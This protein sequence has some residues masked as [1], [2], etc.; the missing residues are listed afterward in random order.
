MGV[1]YIVSF[2]VNIIDDN[3]KKA[4][5]A[6]CFKWV[7]LCFSNGA[8]GVFMNLTFGNLSICVVCRF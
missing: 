3:C 6:P 8:V 4:V 7:I 2:E 1:K 5:V